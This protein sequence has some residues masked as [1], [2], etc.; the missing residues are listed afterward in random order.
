MLL[1]LKWMGKNMALGGSGKRRRDIKERTS[2]R[3]YMS[4]TMSISAS[5]WAI[6]CSLEIWGRP[7]MPKKDILSVC[8]CVVSLM[9]VEFVRPYNRGKVRSQLRAWLCNWRR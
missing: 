6:F 8:M 7:P 2:Y 4:L 9:R 3:L 1:G 5:A